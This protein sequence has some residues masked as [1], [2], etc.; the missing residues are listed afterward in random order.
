MAGVVVAGLCITP[1]GSRTAEF[2]GSP[3]QKAYVRYLEDTLDNQ[4]CCLNVTG[5]RA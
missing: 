2:S 4:A 3:Y 1:R 5:S